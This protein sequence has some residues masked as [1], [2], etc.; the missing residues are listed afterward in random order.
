MDFGTGNLNA[1]TVSS[2][3]ESD[4]STTTGYN[5]QNGRVIISNSTTVDEAAK[6]TDAAKTNDISDATINIGGYDI[7]I[8]YL[9]GGGALIV[10]VVIL[11]MKK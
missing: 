4:G 1:G 6:T 3:S 7:N 2:S 5:T 9:I 11:S 10:G 8:L